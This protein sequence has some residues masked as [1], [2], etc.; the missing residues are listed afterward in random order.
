LKGKIEAGAEACGLGRFAVLPKVGREGMKFC[1]LHKSS[2]A[3][4]TDKTTNTL[5]TETT[6]PMYCNFAYQTLFL[7]ALVMLV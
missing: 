7:Q 3:R 4:V 6:K 2:Q 5:N 1:G